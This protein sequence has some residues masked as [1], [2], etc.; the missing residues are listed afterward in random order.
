MR[1]AVMG[2]PGACPAGCTLTRA[3]TR[4]S[5]SPRPSLWHAR[6]G[7]AAAHLNTTTTTADSNGWR[8]DCSEL[9]FRILLLARNRLRLSAD[10]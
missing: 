8:P 7:C 9:R 6:P 3:A 2:V 5:R 10:S 4:P 1:C